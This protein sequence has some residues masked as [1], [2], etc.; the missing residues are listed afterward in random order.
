MRWSRRGARSLTATPER[1][2]GVPG[3]GFQAVAPWA[4]RAP[5]LFSVTIDADAFGRSRD[6]LVEHM[7]AAGS[8]RGRCSSPSIGCRRTWSTRTPTRWP[9]DHR[10]AGRYGTQPAHV[11]G[12]DTGRRRSSRRRAV[13]RTAG[14]TRDHR[15]A[16]TGAWP[17]PWAGSSKRSVTN[18]DERFFHPHPLTRGRGHASAPRTLGWTSTS[19][20]LRTAT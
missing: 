18:G 8:K 15:T 7:A 20:P 5:W 14:V 1:L 11:I 3:V 10:A 9:A 16:S 13:R 19:P 17:K 6:E 4:E 12:H 2:S